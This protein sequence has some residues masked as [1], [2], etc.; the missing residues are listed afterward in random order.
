MKNLMWCLQKHMSFTVDLR[1]A[2]VMVEL[3]RFMSEKQSAQLESAA[4]VRYDFY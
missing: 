4:E 1:D 2:V 3:N